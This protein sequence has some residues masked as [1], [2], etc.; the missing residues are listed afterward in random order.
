MRVLSKCGS[1]RKNQLNTDFGLL[2]QSPVMNSKHH[3]WPDPCQNTISSPSTHSLPSFRSPLSS[4]L[5]FTI[6]LYVGCLSVSHTSYSLNP[7]QIGFRHRRK[8]SVWPSPWRL[9]RRN[10]INR[11]HM[12]IGY[13]MDYGPCNVCGP[14]AA[15]VVTQWCSGTHSLTGRQNWSAPFS[16]LQPPRPK[17][18]EDSCQSFLIVA[19]LNS[20][21]NGFLPDVNTA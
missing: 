21:V 13:G 3:Q 15:P 6:A 17:G 1:V 4:S 19:P 9:L 7:K 2:R 14:Q 18:E 10:P 11:Q 5:L 16:L 20:G 12:A 8:P